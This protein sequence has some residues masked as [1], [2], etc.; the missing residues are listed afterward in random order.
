VRRSADEIVAFEDML[1]HDGITIVKLF[2][3]I[4]AD[5]QLRRF[6]ERA[7]NPLKQWKLTDDDW[8]NRSL[9][10]QYEDAIDDMLRW[11][12]HS[13]AHWDV[14]AA[15]NKHFARVSALET[16]I[17][18]WEHDLSRRGFTLPAVREGDYLS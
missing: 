14:I 3:H 2:L 15:E 10:P 16:V 18:R 7:N 13:H 11:T 17:A 12:D 9:R 8:R 5:E 6:N 4:S 1:V